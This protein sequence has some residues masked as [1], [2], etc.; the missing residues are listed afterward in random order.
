MLRE[1][2][3]SRTGLPFCRLRATLLC[4]GQV[5]NPG[6]QALLRGHQDWGE[7]ALGGEINILPSAILKGRYHQNIPFHLRIYCIY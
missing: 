1:H 7:P 4:S 3:I 5:A 6:F 2:N